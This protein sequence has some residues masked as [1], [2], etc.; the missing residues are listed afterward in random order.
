M[1][2]LI[3]V[4]LILSL[5]LETDFLNICVMCLLIYEQKPLYFGYVVIAS[6]AKIGAD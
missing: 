1:S 2:I 3:T 5:E 6:L 4:C